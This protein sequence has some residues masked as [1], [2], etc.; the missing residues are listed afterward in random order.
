MADVNAI[1]RTDAESLIP[2]QVTKEIIQGA[3]AESAVL[4][5]F[6]KLPN[7]A[8]NVMSMPVLDMLPMAYWVNGDTGRKK[9]TKQMW[10]KK[11]IRAEE[12]AVI[13][14][15]PEAVLNDARD[16]GY[17]LF[18]EITPRVNEAFGRAID[19]AILFGVNKPA[20]WRDSIVD[21][22]V[23]A[24]NV[25]TNSGDIF[26]D[27]FGE[28]GVIAKVEQD[29]FDV[30]GMISDISMKGKLRGLR[31]DNKQPLFV[32]DLRESAAPY[33]LD[34]N[35]IKFL[36][37][38]AWDNSIATMIAGD[39]SQAVYS[40]RQ[41]MTVKLLEQAVIQDEEGKIVYNLAQQ[42]MVALR[43]VMRLGWEIPNPIN[44]LNTDKE[45]RCPFAVYKPAL[46]GTSEVP[47]V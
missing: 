11:Y 42:D 20:T 39:M 43:F 21:T 18:G 13:V 17:D 4:S 2:E 3:V 30:N 12:I 1:L 7:M 27:I 41:D 46:V 34:G 5:T 26:L 9:T 29:G 35:P 24:G 36:K 47:Q 33:A 38:G 19:D 31:D 16:N 45:T 32:K 14:P 37:N 8:S 23:N 40:I 44:A 15:I 25:V 22:A 6:R 10:D 28:N